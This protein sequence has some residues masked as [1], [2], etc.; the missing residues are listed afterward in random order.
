MHTG[1]PCVVNDYFAKSCNNREVVNPFF[2]PGFSTGTAAAMPGNDA[3]E[4]AFQRSQNCQG[5]VA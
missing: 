2:G 3:V 4:N 5:R 1:L